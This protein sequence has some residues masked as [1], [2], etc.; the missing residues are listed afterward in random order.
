M[1]Y[2]SMDAVADAM[3]ATEEEIPNDNMDQ[4]S[5]DDDVVTEK[6]QYPQKEVLSTREVCL[7]LSI[8]AKR[9]AL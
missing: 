4:I 7:R 5:K 1:I 9:P 8:G 3:A 2:G 6:K